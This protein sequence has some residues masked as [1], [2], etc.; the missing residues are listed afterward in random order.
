MGNEPKTKGPPPKSPEDEMFDKIWE[1]NMVAKQMS[2]ESAKSEAKEKAS[3]EKVK[4]AIEKG[5]YENAKVFANEAISA[6]KL[7]QTNKMM[8]SKINTIASRLKGAMNTQKLTSA[9]KELSEQMVG[10]TKCMDMVQMSQTLESFEK[11]FDNIDVHAGLM[12]QVFNNVNEGTTNENEV[13]GLLQQVAEQNGL[14]LA[15]EMG[16]DAEQNDINVGGIEEQNKIGQ[17]N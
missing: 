17:N 6:R 9:M 5:D 11:M 8:A 15:E 10:A 16:I 14:K 4:K 3:L 2:K 13:N 1:F 12:D 7:K